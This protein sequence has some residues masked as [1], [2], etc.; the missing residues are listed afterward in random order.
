M[1]PACVIYKADDTRTQHDG[2]GKVAKRPISLPRLSP[3]RT[4]TQLLA[5]WAGRQ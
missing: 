2:V 5:Y 1:T 4:I 3:Y